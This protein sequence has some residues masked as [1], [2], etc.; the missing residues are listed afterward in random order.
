MNRKEAEDFVYASYKKAEKYLDYHAKDGRKRRPEL[1]RELIRSMDN[2]PSVAVTGSKGKGSVA[3]MIAGILQ[4]ALRVGLMTSPH[5]EDFCERFCFNGSPISAEDFALYMS[6][7]RLQ[8]EEIDSAIP[9]W[10]YVSPMGIQTA[11]A[12]AY[13]QA[14]RADFLVMECGKGARYD[15]V[16]NM[17]HGYAVI[18]RI[19]LEHT[20]ELGGSLEEIAADKAHI[21]QKGQKC[22]Y[23]AEQSP[24]AME[25][26][27]E[28]AAA[29]GTP[30]RVYG[31]DFWAEN[32]GYDR[33]GMVFDVV[34]GGRLLEGIRIRLLGEHQ[35]RNCALA[36][37]V[38]L[39]I[40]GDISL[41]PVKKQLAALDWPGRMEL[42]SSQPKILLDACIHR[43]SCAPVKEVM[44]RLGMASATVVIGIPEDKDF[45]GV[46]REMAPVAQAMILTRAGNAHYIF[47]PSQAA[48]V[49]A[50]GV[51]ALWADTLEQA[52]DSA[53]A[54]GGDVVILGTT[55]LVSEAKKLQRAR[56]S[57]FAG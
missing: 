27:E 13:F 25:V 57:L 21:I 22:V 24:E 38:S 48:R 30:L 19:F 47:S 32:I 4:S 18:N 5:L 12:L 23:V 36:M 11:L 9:P 35:A 42:L 53:K 7:L 1:T 3:V 20:R 39:D 45:A 29:L 31:R 10:A 55:S 49:A 6:R 46:A 8:I 2:M 52:L 17:A 40:L 16:S 43:L 14:R 54:W 56:K 26:I 51:D 15:D 41:E 37:A 28:R 50:E 34:V 33:E 44:A